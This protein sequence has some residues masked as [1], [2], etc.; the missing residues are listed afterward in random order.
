[1]G[2][3]DCSES[4]ASYLLPLI[5]SIACKARRLRAMM[6]A[7]SGGFAPNA[8]LWLGVVEQEIFVDGRLQFIDA[9]I[10]SPANAPRS[11]LGKEVIQGVVFKDGAKQ[12][13][14]G[15]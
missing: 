11:D 10:A 5:S 4:D 15:P 1:M 2:M 8:G 13:H 9:G 7:V 3:L 6:S 12:L 14:K